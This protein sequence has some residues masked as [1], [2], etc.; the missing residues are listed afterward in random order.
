M[1]GGQDGLKDGVGL[2]QRAV[3][4]ATKVVGEVRTRSR[5]LVREDFD[6]LE[7]G[8]LSHWIQVRAKRRIDSA[9]RCYR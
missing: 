9:R 7:R 2:E 6:D 8:S 1:D 3:A 4:V 5:S